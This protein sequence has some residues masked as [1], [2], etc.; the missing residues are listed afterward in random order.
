MN[1]KTRPGTQTPL[2]VIRR[3]AVDFAEDATKHGVAGGIPK[4]ERDAS[5]RS[6]LLSL[7]IPHEYGSLGASWSETLQAMRGLAR[8]DSPVAHTYGS[9]HLIPTTVHLFSRSEQ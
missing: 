6:D 5:R 8:V 2:Q 9:Q 4:V 1:A 3:L 7:I